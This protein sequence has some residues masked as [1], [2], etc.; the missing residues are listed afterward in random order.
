LLRPSS[1][2]PFLLQVRAP[3]GGLKCQTHN[4]ILSAMFDRSSD[5][6][7]NAHDAVSELLMGMRLRGASYGRLQLTPPFGIRF[8]AGPEAR[9]HFIARGKVLLR[10]PGDMRAAVEKSA[11][12]AAE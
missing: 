12:V 9:F 10:A 8:S 4:V 7:Q 2:I 11:T 3:T 1:A 6:S 5:S